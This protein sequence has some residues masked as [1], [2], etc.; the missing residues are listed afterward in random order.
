MLI[1]SSEDTRT[2]VDFLLCIECVVEF[3]LLNKK[4]KKKIFFM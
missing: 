3:I 4:E 2:K 1:K